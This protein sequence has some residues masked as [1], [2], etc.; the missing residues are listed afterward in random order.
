MN[1][2]WIMMINI[3]I[4]KSL[5]LSPSSSN[6]NNQLYVLIRGKIVSWIIIGMVIYYLKN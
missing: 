3:V 5:F 1:F 6:S 2:V 4:Q